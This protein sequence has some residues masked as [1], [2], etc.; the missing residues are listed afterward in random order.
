[1]Q[2]TLSAPAL[3]ASLAR[4]GGNI[5]GLSIQG[6]DTVG[7]RLELLREAAPGL[8]R[9][10]IMANIGNPAVLLEMSEAQ[11]AARTLGLEVDPARS[12]ASRKISRRPS[13]HSRI[14]RIALYVAPDPL[15]F[16]NRIR[17]N[18]LALAARLPTMHG[19]REYRGSGR[20]DVL[21]GE[22]PGPVAARRRLR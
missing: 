7:K 11:A 15:M 3:V 18:T 22:L 19:V 4:P 14:A 5:T 8:R 1:M 17:I 20:S 10:A 2:V 9:L 6:T 13:R 21:W 12:P 16:T